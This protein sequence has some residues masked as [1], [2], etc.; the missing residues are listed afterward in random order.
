MGRNLDEKAARRISVSGKLQPNQVIYTSVSAVHTFNPAVD[1]TLSSGKR[2]IKEEVKDESGETETPS[3]KKQKLDK[4]A[5]EEGDDK[6]PKKKKKKKSLNLRVK[7][8]KRRRKRKRKQ[9]LLMK[10]NC[11]CY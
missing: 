10:I 8:K 5:T 6:T 9:I 4:S 1:S 2:K 3:A 7:R 11:S